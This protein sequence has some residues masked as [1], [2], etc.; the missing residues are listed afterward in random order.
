MT[1]TTSAL[2]N[3]FV[4]YGYKNVSSSE[5][6]VFNGY[7]VYYKPNSATTSSDNT[8]DYY[9]VKGVQTIK[10]WD[11][12][13][14]NYRFW[15]YINSPDV[16]YDPA[17]YTLTYN[18]CNA[19]K[20]N[21]YLYSKTKTVVKESFGKVVQMQFVSPAVK[22]RVC[23][24]TD[25][26]MATTDHIALT[27]IAFGP[28]DVTNPQIVTQGTLAVHYSPAKANEGVTVTPSSDPGAVLTGINYQD[29]DLTYVNS[30]SN[31]A[32][33]AILDPSGFQ[34]MTVFPHTSTAMPTDFRL[35]LNMDGDPKTAEVPANYMRWLPNYCY[36]YL[37]K[38]SDAGTKF[39][40]IDLIIDPWTYGGIV[41]DKWT[42]W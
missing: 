41:E 11:Y 28:I 36:T 23:F 14:T 9:Y 21:D 37:F 7:N 5:K 16:T 4:V 40:F 25:Q 31:T 33:V 34:E 26:P 27:N 32:K 30:T 13:A 6:L 19:T 10:Y 12:A 15:G 20:L 39:E 1:R 2:E 18:K 3:D 22:V 8:N 24:Y 29:L 17:A 35:S 42:T 38:I